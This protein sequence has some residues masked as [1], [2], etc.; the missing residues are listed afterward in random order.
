MSVRVCQACGAQLPEGARFC[1]S[2]GRAAA[3]LLPEPPGQRQRRKSVALPLVLLA[4]LVA[5]VLV[6]FSACNFSHF[7]RQGTPI[8]ATENAALW[9]KANTALAGF[10]NE[11]FKTFSRDNKQPATEK[12]LAPL[13]GYINDFNKALKTLKG[14]TPPSEQ[15]I[16]H[17][18]LL[19]VYQEMPGPMAGVRDALLD[20]DTWATY[21]EWHKLALLMDE[22]GG[23]TKILTP[24]SSPVVVVTPTPSPTPKPTPSPTPTPTPSPTPK[25]TPSPTTV[26]PTLPPAIKV[27]E[28]KLLFSDDF[29]N[30]KSGWVTSP[31]DGGEF[32]YENGEYS[33]I[34]KKP[35]WYIVGW[36][37][38]MGSQTDFAVE[39]EGRLLSPGSDGEYGIV[40]RRENPDI[41]SNFYVFS[42]KNGT[43]TIQKYIQG[44]WSPIQNWTAS[45]YI[46]T[47]QSTNLLKLVGKGTQVDLYANGQRLT[48]I[49]DASI[50]SGYIGLEAAQLNA[51][52][53]FD[54]F[55]LCGVSESN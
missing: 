12:E 27:L 52:V 20:G 8:S 14:V 41:D 35:Q 43:Y 31:T 15:S 28:S 45:S 48:S 7:N 32:S 24:D 5:V 2:C 23:T 53:H 49:N 39:V 36:D 17:R 38:S 50:S 54:N 19:P 55:K 13:S 4:I 18:A 10:L 37:R 34:V 30:P 22:V 9:G 1:R 21:L 16:M 3:S 33:L 47:G 42:I 29:S 44:K 40:F 46:G 26:A 51:H 11:G 6:S 25:P